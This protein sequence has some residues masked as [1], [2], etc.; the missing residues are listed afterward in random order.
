MEREKVL[1]VTLFDD[2]NYGNRL[3]N[4]A[5]ERI[6]SEKG[7]DVYVLKNQFK[8]KSGSSFIIGRIKQLI[9]FGLDFI[10]VRKYRGAFFWYLAQRERGKALRKFDEEN[11]NNIIEAENDAAFNMDW[12]EYSLAVTGSDQVWHGW[13]NGNSIELPYY[14][15]SF[16]SPEKRVAYGASFGFTKIPPD[17]LKA[18]EEGLKNM[19]R[20]SMREKSG[21]LIAEEITGKKTTKVLDPTLLLSV[22]EWREKERDA[23]EW[24][25]EQKGYGFVFFLGKRSDEYNKEIEETLEREGIKR[26]ID[27]SNLRDLNLYRSGPFDFVTL[28]DNADFVF[29]DSF[30]C[31]VFCVLFEKKFTAF[32]RIGEGMEDMFSRI[33]ELLASTGKLDSIYN[34][35][36]YVPTYNFEELKENSLRYLDEILE[37]GK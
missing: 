25:N 19:S 15:L 28:I 21:C 14:Y 37:I 27:F 34:G 18:H 32:R 6:L 31:C 26:V 10:G 20:I 16:I 12:S 35:T 9:K 8:S 2:H 36:S 17:A 3:Q 33:E 30:H 23:R 22:E 4:Y 5:L 7:A 1:L 24:T 13:R 11:I 29:T